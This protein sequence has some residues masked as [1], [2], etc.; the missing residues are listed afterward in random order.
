MA[1]TL[2]QN[3]EFV[4][5][6]LTAHVSAGV[7]DNKVSVRVNRVVSHTKLLYVYHMYRPACQ[8]CTGYKL[9]LQLL[10]LSRMLDCT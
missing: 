9:I 8:M 10:F 6:L 4:R 7:H 3:N 2:G 5:N 1:M